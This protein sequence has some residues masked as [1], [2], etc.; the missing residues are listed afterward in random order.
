MRNVIILFLF[1]AAIC[2]NGQADSTLK[3]TT[4]EFN[5][6]MTLPNVQLLDVR[7]AAEYKSGHIKDSIQA[8]RL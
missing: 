1:S 2:C 8:H 4:E 5:K 3:V 7:T 6:G